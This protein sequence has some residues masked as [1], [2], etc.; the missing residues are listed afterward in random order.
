MANT[1]GDHQPRIDRVAR[2]F[3]NRGPLLPAIRRA[4]AGVA[5]RLSPAR[6]AGG[7]VT[8]STVTPDRIAGR[9]N[10]GNS[11]LLFDSQVFER[12]LPRATVRALDERELV[13]ID[14]DRQALT[15]RLGD[16]VALT[17]TARAD[18]A[19]VGAGRRLERPTVAAAP[20]VAAVQGDR[21]LFDEFFRSR[22]YALLPELSY[23]L[24]KAGATGQRYQPSLALHSLGLAAAGMLGVDPARPGLTYRY[25]LPPQLR[26]PDVRG[27]FD[28][29]APTD[30]WSGPEEGPNFDLLPKCEG[31]GGCESHPNRDRDCFGMCG[32]GCDCWSWICGDCCYHDFCAEHD[33]LLRSCDGAADVAL[34]VASVLI[35][36]TWL[37]GCDHGWLPF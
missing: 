21:R 19:N 33:A 35:L 32:S 24:G 16:G 28:R 14:A 1:P 7:V 5:D 27:L 8:L 22:E 2:N 36:P 20:N 25:R 18:V 3:A 23:A 11:G 10:L 30:C 12:K 13:H 29:M 9:L 37:L 34:C 6:P 17:R 31:P 15:V 4:L 26:R